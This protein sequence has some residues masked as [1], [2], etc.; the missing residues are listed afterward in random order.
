M[1]GHWDK[2]KA[3]IDGGHF[4]KWSPFCFNRHCLVKT[5][6]TGFLIH[7]NTSLVT[8]IMILRQ[9]EAEIGWRSKSLAAILKNGR[10]FVYRTN[11]RWPYI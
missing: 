10:H 4:S 1:L 7:D 2:E 11:L 9:L 3:E 8:K 5:D 6:I